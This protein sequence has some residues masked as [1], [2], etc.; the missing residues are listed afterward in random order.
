MTRRPTVLVDVTCRWCGG[1]F[2]WMC[3]EGDPVP[4]TC[5]AGCTLAEERERTGAVGCVAC[6][7]FTAQARGLCPGCYKRAEPRAKQVGWRALEE[8]G[9]AIPARPRGRRRDG[10]ANAAWW[11]VRNPAGKRGAG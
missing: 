7:R 1:T 5:S 4:A 11:A 6:K 9:E 2:E 3:R 10:R 8:A